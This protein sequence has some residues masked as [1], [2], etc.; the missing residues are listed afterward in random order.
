MK[1]FSTSYV[2]V[3]QR[4]YR[5][6]LLQLLWLLF[7]LFGGIVLGLFPATYALVEVM[8]NKEIEDGKMIFRRFYQVYKS[9]WLSLNTAGCIWVIMFILMV[10]NIF[11]FRGLL[12]M[13]C[14]ITGILLYMLLSLIYFFLFYIPKQ[15]IIKQIYYSFAYGFAFP[16]NNILIIACLVALYIGI[17]MV[18]GVMFFIGISMS[19]FLFE[20]LDFQLSS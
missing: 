1:R 18:P 11:L 8:K 2:Q 6:V 10:T 3:V 9:N 17:Q 13:Q 19:F 4:V 20:K 7:T 14:I 5:L 12:F 15:P 16:K